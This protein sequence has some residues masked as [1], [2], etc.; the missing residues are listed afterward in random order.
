MP[1]VREV[2]VDLGNVP[3]ELQ[4]VFE[5]T[6]RIRQLSRTERQATPRMDQGHRRSHPRQ[7]PRLRST[8]CST[9]RT[10]GAI[11]PAA[12]RRLAPLARIADAPRRRLG[13]SRA[14][15]ED[16]RR[17]PSA[18]PARKGFFESLVEDVASTL[19]DH[20][21]A[22]IV[23]PDPHAYN[24]LR[25]VYPQ[26]GHEYDVL[27]YTQLFAPLIDGL[28][29]K[30]DL[31]YTV[32]FHDPCYLGRHN[33]EYDA[34]R[35]LLEAIP[36]ITLTE[37]ARCKE[38]G[39][40]C[41]GGG[42]GMWLDGLTDNYTSERLSERPRSSEAVESGAD[43]LAV[44]CPYEVS[45]FEDAAK[46]T[47]NAPAPGSR[48]RRVD[49]SG[50]GSRWRHLANCESS[51]S[52]SNRR[53]GPRPS[54]MRSPTACQPARPPPSHSCGPPIP[55]SRSVTTVDCRR[56]TPICVEQGAGPS[57]AGW[58]VVGPSISTAVSSSS[59]SRCRSLNYHPPGTWP[60][61]ASSAPRWR[62]YRAAG[63][64][65]ELDERLEIVVGDRKICG[66]RG[67]PDRRC[68]DSRGQPHRD[69]RPRSGCNRFC[70]HPRLPLTL[71]D[72]HRTD[73]S[74]CPAHAGRPCHLP[75]S[76]NRCILT[77]PPPHAPPPGN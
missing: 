28:E 68:R 43:V 56:S 37:M 38:N 33:G 66:Y 47:G 2:A 49:R 23:T 73:A 32:T 75:R 57:I 16:D 6:F 34:P 42:G 64:D 65:A 77:P 30:R 40:C 5:K 58:S 7:G 36:G 25:N 18:S 54:G 15:R 26:Y 39:Y 19:A 3:G 72:A 50:H 46:S 12:R 48:H 51:T 44:C 11:T 13:H 70:T 31:D 21:F 4:D 52:A 67:R 60:C 14:R 59:R 24:A 17:L 20:E 62:P 9:W 61:A 74:L 53:Y 76:G 41:G 1:A 71:H 29:W 55:M 63:I 22:R 45:R 27:H 69:L 10:T 8:F 35:K